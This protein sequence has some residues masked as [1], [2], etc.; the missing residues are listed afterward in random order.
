[1]ISTSAIVVLIVSIVLG[2][3]YKPL[4]SNGL[5]ATQ[6]PREWDITSKNIL[7]VT[8]H[9]DDE[10]MF[11]APTI[12]SLQRKA[13][14]NLYHLCLSNGNAE[15]LGETR[16]RELDH[17]L[18]ILGIPLTKRWLIN[19][20]D[21]QDNQTASWNADVI[22]RSLEPYVLDLN[23]D[24]ILT[25]DQDGVSSHPNHKSIPEGVKLLIQNVRGKSTA[26]PRLYTLVSVS[27]PLKYI[28]F[29]SGALTKLDISRYL[30]TLQLEFLVI[31]VLGI[32]YPDLLNPAIPRNPEAHAMPTFVLGY[33]GYLKA[34]EAMKAHESQLVWFRYLYVAFSRYMWVNTYSQVHVQL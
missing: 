33:Q 14:V 5:F 1:M 2:A 31:R 23:V 4:D 19:H 7:L 18:D 10:T 11:F 25:F 21:L 3:L 9:P 26:H 17:S 20:P 13:D 29:V 27:L 8:A 24:T 32:W 16:R 6:K 30:F 12:L 28:S 15:G 22:A 34:L